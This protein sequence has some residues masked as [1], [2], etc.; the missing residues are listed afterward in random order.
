M[1][2]KPALTAAPASAGGAASL[3]WLL[4]S[5]RSPVGGIVALEFAVTAKSA[6]TSQSIPGAI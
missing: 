2:R 6:I 1:K 5:R 3:A 4:L